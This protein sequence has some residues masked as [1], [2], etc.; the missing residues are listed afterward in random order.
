MRESRHEEHQSVERMC[1]EARS[2]VSNESNAYGI[3]ARHNHDLFGSVNDA[4]AK[5]AEL[6]HELQECAQHMAFMQQSSAQHISMFERQN[7]TMKREIDRAKFEMDD[8][9]HQRSAQSIA[10]SIRSEAL[11]GDVGRHDLLSVRINIAA[12]PVTSR[13]RE[14]DRN[15]WES[16]QSNG[17]HHADRNLWESLQSSRGPHAASAEQQ[18]NRGSIPCAG[19]DSGGGKR[20]E[21][22]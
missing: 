21:R 6:D 1:E 9:T 16:L 2:F 8:M 22:T 10:G 12:K 5:N 15:L 4:N 7:I 11:G 3:A 20:Q 17:G 14:N 19:G 13:P 18:G